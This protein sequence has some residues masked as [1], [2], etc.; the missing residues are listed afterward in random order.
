MAETMR[1]GL[2]L[3]L[4]GFGFWSHDISGFEKRAT[5]DLYKRWVQFGFLSSHSRLHGSTEYKVPWHY[6]DESV[7]ITRQFSKLKN[8]LMPYLYQNAADTAQTGIPM[9]RPM[10]LEF[11]DDEACYYL[12]RQYM[13]GDSL[14]VAPIF[15]DKSVAKYYLPSG[16]WTNYFTNEVKIGEKWH[17]ETHGYSTL[18]LMVRPNTI[19]AIGS[20]HHTAAYSFENE[21]TFHI[22]ELSDTQA[23]ICDINGKPVAT[24]HGKKEGDELTF[25]ITGTL[26]NGYN[27]LLR[28][29]K[30]IGQVENGTVEPHELGTFI[31]AKEDIVI[32]K[33]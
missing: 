1:G 8:R 21:P 19:L 4:S 17:E 14:L 28:N 26:P 25:T 12:D 13:L 16:N 20:K 33:L 24:I 11:P 31:T 2:S 9:M 22:F 10:I 18:P 30:Q 5:D 3:L 23:K 27:I 15:N 6:G 32:V 29:I 7:E